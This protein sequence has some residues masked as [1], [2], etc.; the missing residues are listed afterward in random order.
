[1]REKKA[2]FEFSLKNISG[3]KQDLDHNPRIYRLLYNMLLKCSSFELQNIS[4]AH[5]SLYLLT[6]LFKFQYINY[7]VIAQSV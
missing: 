5:W 1:M 4:M 3:F 6:K 2:E 7:A